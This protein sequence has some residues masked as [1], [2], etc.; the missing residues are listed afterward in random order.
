MAQSLE[1]KNSR[2]NIVGKGNHDSPKRVTEVSSERGKGKDGAD[3]SLCRSTMCS[4]GKCGVLT[5]TGGWSSEFRC[6][7]FLVAVSEA[8]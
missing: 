8:S 3:S 1:L 6:A 5:T 4:S 7:E 2:G